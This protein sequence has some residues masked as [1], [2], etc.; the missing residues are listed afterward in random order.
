M[1]PLI[2]SFLPPSPANVF[3]SYFR[4]ATVSIPSPAAL[5]QPRFVTPGIESFRNSHKQI[6]ETA[7][8]NT[9]KEKVH[10]GG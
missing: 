9:E 6:E 10:F 8:R 4:A 1:S 7:E 5:P 2:R 3:S